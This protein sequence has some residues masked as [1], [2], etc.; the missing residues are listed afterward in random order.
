VS[1]RYQLILLVVIIAAIVALVQFR[2]Q[3]VAPPAAERPTAKPA[4]VQVSRVALPQMLATPAT[5][6]ASSDTVFSGTLVSRL[7]GTAVER[8]ELTFSSRGQV[9][10]VVSAADGTFHF[11]PPDAGTYQLAA[12]AADGFL[13][14]APAWGDSPLAFTARP[15]YRIEGVVIQ[16]EP[17][18]TITA[19]ITDA[20][21]APVPAAIVSVAIPRAMNTGVIPLAAPVT[22]D[23]H[24]IA[25]VSSPVGGI[26]RAE[27]AGFRTAQ[28]QL[29][30]EAWT[31]GELALR[32]PAVE[33][34]NP[35]L[36]ISGTVVGPDRAVLPDVVV[37]VRPS[38]ANAFSLDDSG[39]SAP[40]GNDGS[41]RIAGLAAGHYTLTASSPGL[42]PARLENVAAGST[43]VV[44]QLGDQGGWIAG[45][46]VADATTKPVPS[47][48]V[49]LSLP[50]GALEERPVETRSFFDAQGNFLVGPFAAGS[51]ALRV[52]AHGY[53]TS[54]LRTIQVT[55]RATA[56]AEIRLSAGGALQ[57]RVRDGGSGQ[58]IAGAHVLLEG[59]MI[60]EG[61]PLAVETS[62]VSASDGSFQ[63]SGVSPG[64]HSVRASAPGYNS[65]IM[66]GIRVDDGA[67]ASSVDIPLTAVAPGAEA[68][69]EIAGIGAALAAQQDVLLVGS[70]LPGGGAADAGIVA[71]DQILAID[72]VSVGTMDFQ[73]AMQRI[74]G[75]VGTTVVLM[76]KHEAKDQTVPVTRRLVQA[77]A[78]PTR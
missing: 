17:T 38:S 40:S 71:G 64:E 53:A 66:S 67:T 24:G 39:S 77:P 75:P 20:N 28:V 12:V 1:R 56:Q 26:V 76:V 52:A 21:G 41:F 37:S 59:T 32:L 3:H 36:A 15:G 8:G 55:A 62:A 27:H 22:A 74:R 68:K 4:Q 43:G 23:D 51:Y 25:R 69:V 7:T 78:S 57:G 19:T 9:Y 70:V 35:A 42:V 44:L 11:E 47:F 61:L 50:V 63:M 6:S 45:Q 72:G 49:I 14:F 34:G 31:R 13:P 16:L 5:V 54:K 30:L 33:Q 73:G 10:S 2:S 65:R 60:G 58:G 46:V 29:T 48:V 18:K